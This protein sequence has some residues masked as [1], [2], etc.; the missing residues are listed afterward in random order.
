MTVMTDQQVRF[1]ETL[2]GQDFLRSYSDTV[3]WR[4][5]RGAFAIRVDLI[6]QGK[7]SWPVSVVELVTP[8]SK[9]TS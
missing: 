6:G 5:I 1:G 8:A 7:G 9:E 3:V 4:R 2:K